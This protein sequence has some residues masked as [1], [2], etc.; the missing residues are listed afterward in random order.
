LITVFEVYETDQPARL[1]PD[2]VE[3]HDFHERTIA[4]VIETLS[5][6][7][8]FASRGCRTKTEDRETDNAPQEMLSHLV[9]PFR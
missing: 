4:C 2:I 5:Q 6:N 8:E 7:D 3:A 9:D 1:S